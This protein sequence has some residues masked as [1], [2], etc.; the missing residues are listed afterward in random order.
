MRGLQLLQRTSLVPTV[1]ILEACR[2]RL[3]LGDVFHHLVGNREEWIFQPSESL[4]G[5]SSFRQ[6]PAPAEI[7]GRDLPQP[8]RPKPLATA[9]PGRRILPNARSLTSPRTAGPRPL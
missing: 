4:S 2:W 1:L 6:K 9:A 3:S 8:S 5:A 7:V